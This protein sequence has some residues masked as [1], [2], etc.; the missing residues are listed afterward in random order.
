MELGFELFS[1]SLALQT[2]TDDAVVTWAHR[3]HL[4][5][6][7]QVGKDASVKQKAGVVQLQMNSV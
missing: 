2:V 6:K 1:T 3:A 4:D 7:K 5:Y